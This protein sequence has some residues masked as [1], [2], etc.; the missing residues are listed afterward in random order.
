M[1]NNN[2]N[3]VQS[4][5]IVERRRREKGCGGGDGT[6]STQKLGHKMKKTFDSKAGKLSRRLSDGSVRVELAKSFLNHSYGN[7]KVGLIRC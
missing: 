5:G 6:G 4:F 1:E 7:G 2:N 3:F